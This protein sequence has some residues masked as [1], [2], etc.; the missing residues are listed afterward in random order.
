[1]W[2]GQEMGF[3]DVRSMLE[4]CNLVPKRLA[5]ILTTQHDQDVHKSFALKLLPFMRYN[6]TVYPLKT[7]VIVQTR[8]SESPFLVFC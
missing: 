7:S 2:R 4:K 1:M 6:E 3:D 5:T 8:L